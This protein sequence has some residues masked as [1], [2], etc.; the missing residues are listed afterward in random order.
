[1][2]TRTKSTWK[3][4]LRFTLRGLFVT[5]TLFMLWG[6]YHTN[7]SREE[8]EAE[9]FFRERGA[10]LSHGPLLMGKGI[11]DRIA[12]C[13]AKLVQT[14]WRERFIFQ[15]TIIGPLTE[16]E[17]NELS[18][19]LNLQHL[20]LSPVMT[21]TE[22]RHAILRTKISEVRGE[23][24]RGALQRILAGHKLKSLTFQHW[25]LSDEDCQAIA[26][27]R[28]L[29][30]LSLMGCQFSGDGLANLVQTPRL[31]GIVFPYCQITSTA[32]AVIPGS[33]SLERVECPH[34]PVGKEFG[35]FIGRSPKVRS[36]YCG[37]E[38]INDEF[39]SAI[40]RHPSIEEL[41]IAPSTITR[42]SVPVFAQMRFLKNMHVLS[43]DFSGDEKVQLQKQRP[44]LIVEYK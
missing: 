24:P 30:G 34:T 16:E 32:L 38:S 14:V 35:D 39:I 25:A 7:R 44:L 10:S 9:A 26:S 37:H 6:G 3:P 22:E 41:S 29:E 42:S 21:T 23:L 12:W 18:K 17:L 11:G 20:T 2:F 1:M 33:A 27:H 5:I 15:A 8:R 31:R 4:R 36:L 13:Y 19:L 43:P 40:G 28:Y